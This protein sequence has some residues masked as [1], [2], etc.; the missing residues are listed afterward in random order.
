MNTDEESVLDPEGVDDSQILELEAEDE[1]GFAQ[2]G[3]WVLFNHHIS[4][5]ARL[6]YGEMV[7][8]VNRGRRRRSGDTDVWPT[9]PLLAVLIG[10]G[11]GDQ[12]TPYLDELV[13]VGAIVRRASF[14]PKGRRT[15]NRYGVRFNPPR[16]HTNH[17]GV[18]MAHLRP[19]A[20]DKKRVAAEAKAT[21]K[22]IQ[23]RREQAKNERALGLTEPLGLA[24]APYSLTVPA[25]NG[26]TAGQGVPQKTGVR[27]PEFSG[28]T[29]KISGSNNTQVPTTGRYKQA[30]EEGAHARANSTPQ[31]ANGGWGVGWASGRPR[32]VAEPSMVAHAAIDAIA[33][34]LDE[35]LSPEQH[36]RLA[37]MFDAARGVVEDM[38]TAG[39]DLH[40]TH[41]T[42]Y[43]GARLVKTDGTRAYDVLY[44]VLHHRLTERVLR[45]DLPRF[46]ASGGNSEP[47]GGNSGWRSEGRP[48]EP[49]RSDGGGRHRA[50]EPAQRRARLCPVHKEPLFPDASGLGWHCRTCEADHPPLPPSA[51]TD[52]D[53]EPTL[54]Q[55]L[56]S[57]PV[58]EDLPE[59]CGDPR[60]DTRTRI[61]SG[62]GVQA[63]LC[64]TCRP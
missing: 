29:P 32:A 50:P 25:G 14:D 12:V 34:D 20:D 46:V 8:F 27:T 23:A 59:H 17:L 45:V 57:L 56:A 31:N 30:E 28:T 35:I 22:V 53:D 47:R 9:L 49:R 26:K 39:A 1:P 58:P 7:A 61:V 62:P 24:P 60:C 33:Q 21:R 19:I 64:P 41:L 18:I 4:P 37:A 48:D 40:P 3:H 42:E 38:A 10:V 5:V 11:S 52:E 2:V 55:V 36:Q 54:E 43:L 16:G 6:L 13:Q 51:V 44:A 15:R 63:H